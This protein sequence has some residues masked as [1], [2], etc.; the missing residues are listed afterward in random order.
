MLIVRKMRGV[1]P[2]PEAMVDEGGGDKS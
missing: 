1:L 2:L